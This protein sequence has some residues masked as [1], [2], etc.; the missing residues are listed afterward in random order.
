MNPTLSGVTLITIVGLMTSACGDTATRPGVGA[1]TL[2]PP[3]STSM[4]VACGLT[5]F[6]AEALARI[7]RLRTS[8]AD[9]RGAGRFAPAPAL[10]WND[11]LAH[12][13]AAHSHDM[14]SRNFFSHTGSDGRSQRERVDATGY[15]WASIGENID[16]GSTSVRGVV[17]SWMASDHHCANIMN[18]DFVHLGL[19]CVRG[20]AGSTYETYWTMALGKPRP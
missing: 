6:R 20:G 18:P 16:A 1:R 10:S 13:A 17:E 15:A 7:N 5:D 3:P 4:P 2:A 11:S 19:A 8:G 14:A 9:C 12:A